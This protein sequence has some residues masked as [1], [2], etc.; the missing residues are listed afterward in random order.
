M[1]EKGEKPL[2]HKIAEKAGYV[3]A[4]KA[5]TEKIRLIK[6]NVH[7]ARINTIRGLLYGRHS[8]YGLHSFM[9]DETLMRVWE[10]HQKSK[11]VDEQQKGSARTDLAWRIVYSLM[12]NIEDLGGTLIGFDLQGGPHEVEFDPDKH[13]LYNELRDKGPIDSNLIGKKAKVIVPGL[14][15]D[16]EVIF[17][18]QVKL[19]E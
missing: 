8:E 6:E 19:I 1:P 4:D 16:E 18:P 13:N 5:Q 9:T 3:P 11:K 2:A 17:Y 7:R 10:E 15:V 14:K 12:R